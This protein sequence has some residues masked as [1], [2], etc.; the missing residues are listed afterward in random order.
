MLQFSGRSSGKVDQ[1]SCCSHLTDNAENILLQNKKWATN[2]TNLFIPNTLNI[3]FAHV[4]ENENS[5]AK[6]SL[7]WLSDCCC[8]AHQLGNL[9]YVNFPW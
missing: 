2:R 4:D 7:K 9:T 5:K 1:S 8:H 3:S 6:S